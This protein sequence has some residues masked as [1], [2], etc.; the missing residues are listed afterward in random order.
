MGPDIS[1]AIG[2]FHHFI[3]FKGIKIHPQ[4]FTLQIGS[5]VVQPWK[6]MKKRGLKRKFT[7]TIVKAP[8][9]FTNLK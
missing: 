2:Y 3:I 7:A 5:D 9:S 8:N 4:E 6:H 1:S